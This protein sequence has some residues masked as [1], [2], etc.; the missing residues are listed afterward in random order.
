[1]KKFLLAVILLSSSQ[2]SF[3]QN[4]KF[5]EAA[6]FAANHICDCV[7][8]VYSEIDEDVQNTIV[9]MT[10]MSEEEVNNYVVGLDEDLIMR[11]AAQAEIMQDPAKA[12]A[13]DACNQEMVNAIDEK[14]PLNYDELGYTE[15]DFMDRLLKSLGA[16]ESCAFTYFLL[17]YGMREEETIEPENNYHENQSPQKVAPRNQSQS[18][19]EGGAEKQ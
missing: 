12:V 4:D 3:A 10:S 19:E 6:E 2:F 16:K 14:Y 1:M 17:Q 15:A 7:N 9:I 11:L 8:H 18:T 5:D 13:F